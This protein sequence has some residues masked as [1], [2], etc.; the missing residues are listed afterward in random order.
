ML[1]R[2]CALAALLIL[3]CAGTAHAALGDRVL[4][5][6]ST[7]ADVRALQSGLTR[8]GHPAAADGAFGPG[9]ARAVRGYERRRGI[10]VDGRVSRKQGRGI[11]SRLGATRSVDPTATTPGE[12]AVL[13]RDGRTALAP[14]AAPQ[15][16]KDAIAAANEITDKPYRYGGGHGRSRTR[17]TTAPAPS[18]TPCTAAGCCRRRARR[19]ASCPT[20]GPGGASGSRSTPT[21]ATPTPSSP[22]CA[23]T[24]PAGRAGAALAAAARSPRG[25][26]ARHPTGL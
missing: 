18:P 24:P 7:G 16:V 19:A 13:A 14:E 2:S 26:T 12:T 3:A 20:A 25:F 4:R 15:E 17:A 5:R 9:T 6:G 11:A 1:H 23:S 22:A 8:L 10:T 21:A